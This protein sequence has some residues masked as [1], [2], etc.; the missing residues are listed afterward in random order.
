MKSLSTVPVP[1]KFR[2]SVAPEEAMVTLDASLL[3]LAELS[4]S[5]PALTTVFPLYAMLP[6]RISVPVP[7]LVRVPMTPVSSERLP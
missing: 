4:W 5:V 2:L 7:D 6:E 3:A 1:A